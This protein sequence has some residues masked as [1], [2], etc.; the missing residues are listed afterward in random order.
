VRSLLRISAGSL[1]IGVASLVALQ[2]F[3]AT[4][5]GSEEALAGPNATLS[6]DM[7]ISDGAC[8]DIDGSLNVA[9][10]SPFLFAVC[11]SNPGIAPVAAFHYDIIYDDTKVSIPEVANV[12][13]SLDD[14][15]DANSGNTTFAP[16]EF[17]AYCAN[18]TDD[19]GDGFAN[20]GCPVVGNRE[21][22]LGFVEDPQRCLNNVDD[23]ADG[24]IN[25]GCP[26]QRSLG[27]NWTCDGGVGS[28]PTGDAEPA[29]GP[30]NGK[31]FSGGCG[32]A[33]GPNYLLS[34][35]LG[36]I[37]G[38]VLQSS[39]TTLT[40]SQAVVTDDNPV[41]I[42]S[43]NP[44]VDVPMTCIGGTITGNPPPPPTF[45]P[46][47]T[48][49]PGAPHCNDGSDPD[50]ELRF[51]G[52][53]VPDQND[54]TW[55]YADNLINECESDDDNDGLEDNDESTGASCDGHITDSRDVDHDGDHLHD[56]WE[57]AFY[58]DGDPATNSDPTDAASKIAGTGA[59]DVDG[60]RVPDIWEARGYNS[61]GGVVATDRDGD[62]CHDLVEIA[63][64]DGN[65]AIG[66]TDRLAVAR[67]A[68]GIWPADADQDWVLD[69]DA[70]GLV[71]DTDRLFV[72]RA[73]LLP[74]W[75]PKLCP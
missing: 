61:S 59:V 22:V 38:T 27:F 2:F 56:G 20:D 24:A 49:T 74:D 42:G 30:G 29:T 18:N 67:R 65:R 41:E 25:D 14:N 26:S 3:V 16:V 75:Q 70:N 47:A 21:H 9:P 6:L 62:G 1:V 63:S 57:C 32:S 15:P 7:E 64:V 40:F 33:S 58:F 69:I 54:A 68:L 23:D 52:P 46:T 50:D 37:S 55:P 11:L 12:A 36:M 5:D 8:N 39:G 60:D 34:G 71:R 19:D 72:A 45:T 31:A 73:A 28:H 10:S 13:P 4:E 44:V 17:G 43:C 48:A 51:N 66:D 35:P 53:N